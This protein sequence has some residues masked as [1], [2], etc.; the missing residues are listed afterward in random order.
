MRLGKPKYIDMIFFNNLYQFIATK[1]IYKNKGF[2]LPN[3][4]ILEI[5]G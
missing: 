2:I 5:L 3:H 4:K 1:G